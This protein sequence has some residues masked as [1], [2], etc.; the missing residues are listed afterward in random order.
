MGKLI[1]VCAAVFTCV[2]LAAAP[3]HAAASHQ[4]VPP[5]FTVTP[6][7]VNGSGCPPGSAAVSQ[8][9][10]TTFTVTYSEYIAQSGDGASVTGFRQNCQINLSIGVPAGWTYG[11]TS[12]DYRGYA[13]LGPGAFGTLLAGYYYAGMQGTYRQQHQISGPMD[14]DYEFNDVA[15]VAAFAPCHFNATMNINTE[16]RAYRGFDRSYLNLLTVDSTDVSIGTI[17]HLSFQQC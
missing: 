7:T 5:W 3:A 4:P 8:T 15:P 1:A 16:L 6:I 13:H 9:S 10:D 17:Y 12:V 11:I 14:G 2:A